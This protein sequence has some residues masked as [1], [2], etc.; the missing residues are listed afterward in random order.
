M[1]THSETATEAQTRPDGAELSDVQLDQ[2]TG[3]LQPKGPPPTKDCPIA[4]E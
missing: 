1:Q 2:V 4:V 3:G